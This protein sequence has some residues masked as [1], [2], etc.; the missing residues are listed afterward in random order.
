MNSL[1]WSI[2]FA[3]VLLLAVSVGDAAAQEK[4]ELTEHYVRGPFRLFYA[5]DGKSAVPLA[6]KDS[7]GVPDHVEDVA[8]QLWA[9]R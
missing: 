6:D 4:S 5:I 8:K 7:S 2:D 3:V 9:A 1:K